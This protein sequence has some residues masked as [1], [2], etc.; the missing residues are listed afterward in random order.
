MRW[1]QFS[2]FFVYL[3]YSKVQENRDNL[4]IKNVTN[5][6]NLTKIKMNVLQNSKVY[7]PNWQDLDTRPL[8]Q[9]YDSAKIGIFVHWGVYSVPGCVSEWFWYYWRNGNREIHDFLKYY[10]HGFTYEEFAQNLTANS[11]NPNKWAKLFAKSGA[12]YVVLTAKHH[13]GF[14]LF[15]S[16]RPGNWN[17][18]DIGPK[19]DV[20]KALSEAVRS[21]KLKFGIYYSLLEWNNTLFLSD[22][23]S[24]NTTNATTNYIEDVL[25]PDIKLLINTYTPSVLWADGDWDANYSYW[26]SPELV[27]WLYNESPVKDEIV[28]NDRWGWG[29]NCQYGDFFNCKDRFNPRTLFPHKWENAFTIDKLSWGF[30]RN[31]KSSEVL[32]FEEILEYVVSTVSCGGNALINVGPTKDGAILPVFQKRLLKLGKW[33]GI[34]G[35]AIYNTSPW[36]FQKDKLSNTD[37]WYTCKTERLQ[38][39]KLM[40]PIESD[41]ITSIYAI[42][43]KWPVDDTLKLYCLTPYIVNEN[44]TIQLLMP[45]GIYFPVPVSNNNVNYCGRQ[46]H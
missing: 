11:F 40:A 30:R 27:A 22:I 25:W 4:N 24:H 37:V 6:L 10:R 43:L 32:S 39:S 31:M 17:S 18:V 35:E 2:V 45:D 23:K 15:P 13:D 16:G 34:N 26:K 42:F 36:H 12:K 3:V 14:T 8:P 21:H 33:L 20:V 41:T 46:P 1:L 5:T 7:S 29:T 38:R 44:I 28:V 19:I 9:W